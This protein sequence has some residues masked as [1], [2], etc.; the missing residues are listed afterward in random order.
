M[1]GLAALLLFQ[2]L[3]QVLHQAG[4]ALGVEMG[5]SLGH[6]QQDGLFGVL[7]APLGQGIEEA[8]GVQLVAPELSPEGPVTVGGVDVHNAAPDGELARA[9]PPGRSGRI[10]R[11]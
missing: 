3:G 9:P 10:R 6:G 7:R 4:H 5:Q 11:R 8:H 1:G 2:Q